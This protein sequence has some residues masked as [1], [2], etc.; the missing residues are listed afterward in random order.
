MSSAGGF[1]RVLGQHLSTAAR[2][3]NKGDANLDLILV[4][5]EELVRDVRIGCHDSETVGTQLPRGVRKQN[6]R[7]QM[8]DIRGP[9][10]GLCWRVLVG[11]QWSAALQGSEN[12]KLI[13]GNHNELF[14]L[15]EHFKQKTILLT[16]YC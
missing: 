6:R 14:L 16:G 12:L 7:L 15:Q 10:F 2:W 13:E 9:D 5:K 11:I 1:W 3:T 4:S 8:L